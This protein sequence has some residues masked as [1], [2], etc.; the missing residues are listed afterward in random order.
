KKDSTRI[1]YLTTKNVHGCEKKDT[2]YFEQKAYPVLPSPN[3][4][5]VTVSNN[6]ETTL[7]WI[8]ILNVNE[9]EI[10]SSTKGNTN[11]GISPY[12]SN[13]EPTDK[14]PI[15]YYINAVDTCGI[16]GEQS[17]LSKSILLEGQVV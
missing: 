16:K 14:I 3:V 17:R 11:T 2:F 15:S 1:I 5:G 10:S 9:Y 13:N 6:N 4:L 8:D 7:E 12:I